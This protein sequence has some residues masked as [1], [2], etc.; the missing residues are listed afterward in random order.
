[1]AA[2]NNKY[3]HLAVLLKSGADPN[4]SDGFSNCINV[5]RK[6]NIN[7]SD[8]K[9]IIIYICFLKNKTI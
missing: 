7:P 8:G 9:Y 5:A 3:E 6:R 1:M 2:S 4:L